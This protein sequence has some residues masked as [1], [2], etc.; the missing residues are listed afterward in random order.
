M[1]R[2]F[3]EI[4]N[5]RPTLLSACAAGMSVGGEVDSGVYEDLDFLSLLAFYSR[6][7][8]EI[9]RFVQAQRWKKL[10][11][12]FSQGPTMSRYV[13]TSLRGFFGMPPGS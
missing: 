6:W 13:P 1:K 11:S 5:G 9:Q 10:V 8:C 4:Y 3:A 12:Y 2:A 7:D